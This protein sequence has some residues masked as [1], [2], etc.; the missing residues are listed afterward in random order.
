MSLNKCSDIL[1]AGPGAGDG[2]HYATRLLA[3]PSAKTNHRF[4][5]SAAPALADASAGRLM[6]VRL[7]AQRKRC[8]ECPLVSFGGR[9]EMGLIYYIA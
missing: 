3:A 6:A 7:P 2:F 4:G 5:G 8:Q 1:P 9:D